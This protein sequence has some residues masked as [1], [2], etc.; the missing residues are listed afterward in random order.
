MPAEA[1]SPS[2]LTPMTQL[3]MSALVDIIQASQKQH[4]ATSE[5]HVLHPWAA[6][7]LAA[8]MRPPLCP[9]SS[10]PSAADTASHTANTNGT[11]QHEQGVGQSLDVGLLQGNVMLGQVQLLG[12]LAGFPESS[13]PLTIAQQT[14]V[15]QV[16]LAQFSQS[17]SGNSACCQAATAALQHMAGKSS[18]HA[19]TSLTCPR[20][21]AM[22]WL[23]YSC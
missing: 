13:S 5:S 9:Q 17:S 22:C 4:S 3:A 20:W 12:A 15:L 1:G 16:L 6:Q 10:Q 18:G 14:T 11:Q 23:A 8:A 7:L 2:Q 19:G 21:S